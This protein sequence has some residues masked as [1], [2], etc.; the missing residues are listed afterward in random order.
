MLCPSAEASYRHGLEALRAGRRR[1]AMALFEA[2]LELEKR[3]GVERPQPRYMSWYGLCVALELRDVREG[4]RYCREAVLHES[5]NPDLHANLGQ[6]LLAA[7]RRRDAFL[8]LARGLRLEPG[9]RGILA[10]M[11]RMG[12]RRRPPLPFLSRR[13][14]INVFLG[15]LRGQGQVS[16]STVRGAA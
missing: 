8:A 9:H 14:P 2:A 4:L 11:R 6:V 10:E 5:Y 13:N 1:E 3:V 7:G 16:R 12:L 15:R